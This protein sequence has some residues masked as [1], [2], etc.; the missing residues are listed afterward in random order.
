MN[1]TFIPW[2][3]KV[4]QLSGQNDASIQ[5]SIQNFQ[6]K[7]SKIISD[8]LLGANVTTFNKTDDTTNYAQS[9]TQFRNEYDSGSAMVEYLG[10][11]STSSID[12]NLDNPDNYANKGKYPV[13]IVNGCLSGNIFDYDVNRLNDKSTLSEKFI[14]AQERGAIG[15]LSSSSYA[16]LSYID[17]FT[18]Q[19]Y[20]C[21]KLAQG[22]GGIA[23]GNN[24]NKEEESLKSADGVVT[25]VDE[26]DFLYITVKTTAGREITLIYLDYVDN[27]D[28]WVK[29]AAT[30]LKDKKVTVQYVEKEVYNPKLKDFSDVKELKELRI[31]KD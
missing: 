9:L 2:M 3:K 30:K 15:Y 28:D 29:N 4:L 24:E 25:K 20:T 12:F 17:L 26:R 6:A 27:S 5:Y 16:V 22:S 14:L 23:L 19:I 8:T 18:Q 1:P 31:K 13:F 11:A 7:Y 10:H 21:M